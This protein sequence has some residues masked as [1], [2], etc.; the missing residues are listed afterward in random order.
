MKYDDLHL[1][2][3]YLMVRQ[4]SNHRVPARREVADYTGRDMLARPHAHAS[5]QC[6]RLSAITELR[7]AGHRQL[8]LATS[9]GILRCTTDTLMFSLRDGDTGRGRRHARKCSEPLLKFTTMPRGDV[10]ALQQPHDMR[11][12]PRTTST[13]KYYVSTQKSRR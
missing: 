4:S 13:V 1:I 5:A 10:E 7:G 3:L 9:A 6:Y 11:Q 2:A 8:D 12:A